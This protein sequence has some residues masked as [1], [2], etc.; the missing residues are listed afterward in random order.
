[1]ENIGNCKAL[2]I[3]SLPHT[4]AADAWDDVLNYFSKIPFWPQLPKRRYYENMYLQFSEHIPGRQIDLENQSFF[5]DRTQDLQPAMERFYQQYLSEDID[6]LGISREY[7]EGLYY[8]LDLL[9]NNDDFFYDIEF[10]KGQVTGPVSFGLQVVDQDKKPIFYDEMLHD[11][12]LKNLERKTRW[13]QEVL[14]KI[15]QNMIISV[16]EP[17]LSSIGSGV[18]ILNRDQVIED[19]EKIFKVLTCLKATHCCGNTDWSLLLETS[20]DIL[21][22][23]A[24]NYTTHLALFASDL[25]SFLNRGGCLGWGIVPS[26]VNELEKTGVEELI[27]RLEDG[28]QLLVKKGLDQKSILRQSYVTPSCG[29]GNISIAHAKYAMQLTKTISEHMRAKYKLD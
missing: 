6:Q 22:F 10:I 20:A 15:N 8:A 13:Q 29:L 3:G 18:L 27:K 17:Y 9:D 16:D 1:M 5:I 2:G 28:I 24:Y 19:I 4:N 14:A 7:I 11:I 21:L 23:D 12:L 26:T 25:D